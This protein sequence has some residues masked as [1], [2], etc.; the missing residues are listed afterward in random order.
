MIRRPTR[1]TAGGDG[2]ASRAAAAALAALLACVPL[3]AQVQPPAQTAPPAQT[4]PPAPNA[5]DALSFEQ[6]Y[7]RAAR[8]N[9]HV[10]AVRA[11]RAVAVAAL[12]I[13]GA[14]PNP[15]FIA[16][17]TRSEPRLNLSL[18]QPVEIGG[19][20]GRRLDVA[21]AELRL[22][23]LDVDAALRTLRRDVRVAY[24]NLALARGT[25]D[26]GQR[27]VEG[28]NRIVEIAE[29][30]FEAGDVAQ[31][32][33]LQARLAAARAAN[34]LARLENA[35]R[36]ALAVLNQLS[37]RAPQAPLEPSE[38]I[39]T[40]R[41][42]VNIATLIAQSLTQNVDL[43]TAEGLIA[44]EQSRLRLA[45]AARV[46]TPVLEPGVE[47]LDE[48]LPHRYGVK[49]QVTVPLP[50][51]NRGRGEIARSSALIEQLTAE[52][53]DARQR[54][55]AEI[56]Q[57]ALRLDAARQQVNFY[58][59]SLLPDAERVRLL[60][61]EAYRAGQTGLLPVLDAQRAALEVRQG[62][63]QALFDYQTALADLEQAAGVPLR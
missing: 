50:L 45:R 8:D 20:R 40:M 61:E 21:R 46:P 49:M 23:D 51:F 56:G 10:R 26:L 9:A 37:N 25:R 4:K 19:Q 24:F 63:L 38:S 35:R 53:D 1:L 14:R 18:S 32:E 15:D 59:T 28:A 6:T 41:L 11:R 7:E 27:S 5:A 62:Y 16:G 47:A 43:R 12:S 22:T 39:F 13:A 36:G 58:E 29:A 2:R 30:R 48:S 3:R 42:P 44:A 52:R 17:Y 54:V 57:A 31:F 55:S 33:V 60:A 34:D